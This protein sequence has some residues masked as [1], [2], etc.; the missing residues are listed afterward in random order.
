MDR[1]TLLAFGLIG[2]IIFAMP[3]YFR[4]LNGEP[5]SLDETSEWNA[6]DTTQ[7]FEPANQDPRRDILASPPTASPPIASE[8]PSAMTSADSSTTIAYE[9]REIIVETDRY[10]ATF[11][12]RGAQVV[13]WRL[14]DHVDGDG[15]PLEL[16]EPG[17]SGLGLAVAGHTLTEIEFTPSQ[18]SLNLIGF[19]QGELIFTGKSA[20]K[21]VTTRILFQGNRYRIEY[22]V[23]AVGLTTGDKVRL[24]WDTFP[25]DTEGSGGQSGGFYAIDYDQV[26]TSAGGEVD[27]WTRESLADLEEPRPSGRIGWFSVRGKYFMSA[28]IPMHHLLYDLELYDPDTVPRRQVAAIEA[29]YPGEPLSFGIYIGPLSYRLLTQQDT[30]LYGRESSVGLDDMVQFGW[31]FLR[32]VL[33][34]A[35]IL[36]IH[37][38]SALRN[39]IPNYGVVIIIFSVLVKIVLFPLT[40]KST[41]ATAKMQQLQPQ[42]TEL[43]EKLGDNQQKLNQEMMKLY[44]DQKVNPLGGCLPLFLQAPILFSLFNVFRNA[45][46]LRQAGFIGWMTD[47]SKPDTLVIGGFDLHVLP[48]VMAGSMFIQQKMTMKDPKQAALVYIMPVFMIWI[49]WSMSS[50]L[51]LYFTMYNLLSVFEQ[52]AVK[53]TDPPPQA[54]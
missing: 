46:E 34:P 49:F 37:A 6:P 10:S 18:S 3:Y 28:I 8:T 19:E 54:A 44:K 47:L 15:F 4:W 2:I 40:R 23:S 50:G 30:D 27:N 29:Q 14:K 36:I 45:I 33:K 51:V 42:I 1:R 41:E 5:L 53:K 11:S 7:P 13:S 12:T 43:R 22:T 52:K 21:D 31:A 17:A 24:G 25:A 32:P 39:A 26:V 38:F 35:T 20:G 48:L 16:I 9:P